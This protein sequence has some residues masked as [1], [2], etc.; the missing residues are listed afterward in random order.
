MARELNQANWDQRAAI[1]DQDPYY[2][3]AGFLAGAKRRT[4]PYR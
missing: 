2:D 4:H 1:H 3:L